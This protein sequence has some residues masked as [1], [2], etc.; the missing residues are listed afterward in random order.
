MKIKV[1]QND[2]KQAKE[3]A[4]NKIDNKIFDIEDQTVGQFYDLINEKSYLIIGTS[5]LNKNEQIRKL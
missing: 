3:L 2:I 5:L 1:E 4:L